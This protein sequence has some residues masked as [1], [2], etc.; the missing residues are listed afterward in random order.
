MPSKKVDQNVSHSVYVQSC[1]Q[2]V[3]L[4]ISQLLHLMFNITI[5][6]KPTPYRKSM[7]VYT[8]CVQ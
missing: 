7:R 5:A 4:P 2:T 6:T 8:M 1:V 3:G